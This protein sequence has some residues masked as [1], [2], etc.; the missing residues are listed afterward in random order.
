VDE[1]EGGG[2]A[3]LGWW[4]GRQAPCTPAQAWEVWA[5]L[6]HAPW[7]RP[8]EAFPM[9]ALAAHCTFRLL[10]FPSFVC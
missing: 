2:L 10:A 5:A 7:P 9:S 8:N 4:A 3:G 6:L 1:C